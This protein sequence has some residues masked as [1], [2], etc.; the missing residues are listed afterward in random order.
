MSDG[1]MIEVVNLTKRYAGHTAVSNISFTV[2]RGEI[3]GLL[4]PN[5]AGKSTIMRILSCF[6]RR[7]SS[8][9]VKTSHPATRTVPDVAGMNQERMRGEE[10]NQAHPYLFHAGDS[11]NCARGRV[12][13]LYPVGRGA[14]ADWLHAG[15]QPPA[16]RPACARI[17]P[18]PLPPQ[19]FAARE[20]TGT[21]R[22][23]D[24]TMR[25]DRCAQAHHRPA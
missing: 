10:H 18:V 7:T 17:S 24:A 11:G 13:R 6:R 14:P 1:P 21:H 16:S 12:R 15:E 20:G 19:R 23:G 3:V 8:D 2:G 4:G 22:H 9:W 25:P 5:G